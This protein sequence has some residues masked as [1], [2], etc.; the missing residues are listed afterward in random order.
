MKVGISIGVAGILI[1]LSLMMTRQ[2]MCRTSCWADNVFK[3]FLPTAYEH[4]AGGLPWVVMGLAIIVYA[5]WT[6]SGHR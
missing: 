4:L 3:L 6:D 5:V 1:G 2:Q